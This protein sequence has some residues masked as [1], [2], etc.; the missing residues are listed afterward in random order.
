M[1]IKDRGL[2]TKTKLFVVDG[3]RLI[4]CLQIRNLFKNSGFLFNNIGHSHKIL[5]ALNMPLYINAPK[6]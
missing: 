6:I 5:L 4:G 3:I 2:L 1:T